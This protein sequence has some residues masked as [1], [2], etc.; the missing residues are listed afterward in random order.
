MK[1]HGRKSK[2]LRAHRIMYSIINGDITSEQKVCHSCDSTRCIN[3]AHLWLGTQKDN[4]QDMVAKGRHNHN[5]QYPN[6]RNNWLKKRCD[7]M[8]LFGKTWSAYK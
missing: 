1:L 3:P 5:K 8:K 4:I 7:R 2:K 6:G